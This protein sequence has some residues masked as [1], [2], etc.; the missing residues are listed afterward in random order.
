[1][2][3]FSASLR[4]LALPTL[5]G[6]MVLIYGGCASDSL[7]DTNG[8]DGDAGAGTQQDAGGTQQDRDAGGTQP[9]AECRSASDCPG[10]DSECAQRTC[11][12]NKCGVT[13]KPD[14]FPSSKQTAGDC[15]RAVCD[16]QGSLKT[17]ADD[18]DLPNDS[19]PCTQD[20]CTSGV[21][22][23]PAAASG[24]E[25]G[26]Q[27]T[28]D[29]AGNCTGCK[30]D[31]DCGT[32][33]ACTS[34]TCN[35][36]T[37]ACSTV[38]T[39]KGDGDPGG[40]TL[41]DCK[42]TVCNGQGGTT[43][44]DDDTDVPAP[45]NS[46]KVGVCSMGMPDQTPTAP[47]TS[48]GNGSKCDGSGNCAACLTD[49][50]C[51][52]ATACASFS[53]TDGAC[54]PHY[55]ANGQGNP[56]G[57]IEGDCKKVTCDGQGGT[58]QVD[59]DGDLPDDG[60]PCTDDLCTDGVASNEPTH[61]GAVCGASLKCDGAGK[62][63]GC[64]V[65]DDCGT[66][67]ACVTYSC[68][69]G[70]CVTEDTPSSMSCP[71]DGDPCTSDTCNGTGTCE[72]P[73]ASVGTT[74]GAG[75]VCNAGG[76]CTDGCVIGGTF[77]AASAPNPGN[78]CQVCTPATSTSTWSNRTNGFGCN[79]GDSC[80]A[81]DVCTNG[82]CA[83]T[84][85]TCTTT[86]C[87]ANSTC[88]GS[89]GCT[90]TNKPNGASCPDDGN[91]CTSDTCDGSGTCG[92]PNV[93]TGTSCGSALVCNAG[94]CASGCVIGGTFF[95]ADAP[96]PSNTCQVCNPSMST[97]SWS[98]APN[99]KGCNDGNACTKGDVCQN[100]TCGGTAYTCSPTTCQATSTCDGNG[101]CTATNKAN[102]ASCTD[103]GN[104]CTTDTCNGSGTCGHSPASAGT[105]CGS[106]LIC[107]GGT[108]CAAACWIN[109]TLYGNGVNNHGN[110]CQICNSSVSTSNWT[111]IANG[112]LG[113]DGVCGSGKVNDSCGICGGN[114]ASKGCD[115][116]CGSG[117]VIDSCGIC[118]GNNA[119]R[120]C[121][122]VCGSGKVI[123]SC[124]VCGGSCI[125]TPGDTT[126]CGHCGDGTQTC[127]ADGLSWGDCNGATPDDQVCL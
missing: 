80:T 116:V 56:G 46:C 103:D 119:T 10:A 29:G 8:T 33:T 98:S 86:S 95:T 54:V 22:S 25:C 4:F 58:T 3:V 66:S 65:A 34:F 108:T 64:V 99:G 62:C 104:A 75:H 45:A 114:N 127:A 32:P 94:T 90:V 109:G 122:G 105:S 18:N 124:G 123:D 55:V 47:G 77:Y 121:D 63:V 23:H 1:M 50:D 107:N 111:N 36:S 51:G 93:S 72:H 44:V 83:G 88:D 24:I 68:Q 118:G 81:N 71:D 42:K 52:A 69:A 115:G 120:G 125:C 27:L 40:Q 9:P 67:S 14:G 48:C 43:T 6:S 74:C 70:K 85:Y 11:T 28:C 2:A 13:F 5:V 84:P 91:A 53:C 12:A 110:T 73:T 15:Q 38:Y 82:T 113:C 39:A 78:L 16:G 117:K 61:V 87:Q 26:Q 49:G 20:L 100:G 30:K 37:G 89:G 79:D 76:S 41:G 19:N 31:A 101:G 102:G 97:S 7:P 21:P 17:V 106:G 96:N 92:H 126:E 112:V 57:G 59:D 60:N 35:T